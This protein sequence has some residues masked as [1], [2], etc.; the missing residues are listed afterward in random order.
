M[1]I[2]KILVI[3]IAIALSLV[4]CKKRH[5]D[6]SITRFDEIFFETPTNEL[7][8]KLK[9]FQSEFPIEVLNNTPDD[10]QY[11]ATLLEIRNDSSMRNIYNITHNKYKDL[12]WLEEELGDALGIA[13]K[14][15]DEIDIEHFCTYIYQFE[16]PEESYKYRI[17]ADREKK[18]VLINLEMYALDVEQYQYLGLPTYMANLCKKEYL[19][20][21][22][23]AEIARQYIAKPQNREPNLLDLIIEEGKVLYFLDEVMPKKEDHLKIRY[24]PE[25][26]EWCKKNE[27]NIWTYFIQ[28]NMLYDKDLLKYQNFYDEAPKTNAFKD[29]APRTTQY[30]GWQIV[31]SYMKN[32]KK[33]DMKEL[34]ENNDSQGILMA[35]KYKP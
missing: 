13:Q 18:S 3:S 2:H 1:K 8:D 24:T 23:M 5:V 34:F 32:N 27:K 12:G 6:V 22:I 4:S 7:A 29:S 11:L 17:I 31:R 35:S 30:I 26:L 19:A 9:E 21:D 33:C 20:S 14:E 10:P 25:Q 28:N 15:N 16:F